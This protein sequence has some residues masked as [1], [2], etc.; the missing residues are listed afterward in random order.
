MPVF[1]VKNKTSKKIIVTVSLFA[2]ITLSVVFFSTP[3]VHESDL[4]RIIDKT[5]VMEKQPDQPVF[6]PLQLWEEPNLEA[7]GSNSLV[8]INYNKCIAI[9]QCEFDDCDIEGSRDGRGNFC[10][11]V[12]F[13]SIGDWAPDISL[14]I[15]GIPLLKNPAVYAAPVEHTQASARLPDKDNNAYFMFSNSQNYYG[16]IWVVEVQGIDSNFPQHLDSSMPANV[17][18]WKKL[19]KCHSASSCND[20]YNP[21]NYNHPA[22]I[23]LIDSTVAIA[24]QNYSYTIAGKLKFPDSHKLPLLSEIPIPKMFETSTLPRYPRVRSADAIAFFDVSNPKKPKFIR[25]LIGDHADQWGGRPPGRDISEVAIAKVGNYYH[26]N[27]GGT[28]HNYN[29]EGEH[30]GYSNNY[31]MKTLSAV[32]SIS[33]LIGDVYAYAFANLEYSNI[34]FP[35][36][37][38]LNSVPLYVSDERHFKYALTLQLIASRIKYNNHP[39][40]VLDSSTISVMSESQ[41]IFSSNLVQ[42]MINKNNNLYETKK[43][44][45]MAGLLW[46]SEAC[47]RAWGFQMLDNGGYNVTCH[48]IDPVRE[49]LTSKGR[50]FVRGV[51][52]ETRLG[53]L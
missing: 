19:N 26:L 8:T 14:S 46:M 22:R 28:D 37:L 9:A 49:G 52:P 23:N 17:V 7:A 48:D 47:K 5:F 53:S 38:S 30:K 44:Q 18:W 2:T 25:R 41:S 31:R 39:E 27:V 45:V 3:Y 12:S 6:S 21:G 11:P 10:L 16:F 51:S 34:S 20:E 4:T 40:H 13:S 36:S 1:Q 35:T 33:P 29:G 42:G 24:F 15:F 50:F 32:E 43:K